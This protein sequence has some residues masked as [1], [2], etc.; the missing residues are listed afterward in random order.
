MGSDSWSRDE[1]DGIPDEEKGALAEVLDESV[2]T[3]AVPHQNLIN[4]NACLGKPGGD[5]RTITKTPMLY[6]M[7]LRSD[8]DIRQWELENS[9]PF[10]T[11]KIGS[12]ALLAAL[13]RNLRAELAYWL[14][15]FSAAVVL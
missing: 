3:V 14:D 11:A 1:I 8:E 2:K 9:A 10:D 7:I 13:K 4:L 6:R 12:S 5:T 15:E